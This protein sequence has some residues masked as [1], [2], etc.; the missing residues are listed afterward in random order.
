MSEGR[1]LIVDDNATGRQLLRDTIE[2]EGEYDVV[3][4]ANGLEALEAVRRE[5]PDLVLM[6]LHMPLMD[7]YETT[8]NLK[9]HPETASIPVVA[10]TASHVMS[11]DHQRAI[12]IGCAD[13]LQKPVARLLL[14]EK[15]R[16]HINR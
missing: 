14:L 10:L 1:I 16:Q 11:E 3:T 9:A 13:Y 5:K 7:G 6:D 2:L 15:V 8:E 12:E 4:A